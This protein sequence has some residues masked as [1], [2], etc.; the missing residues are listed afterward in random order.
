MR[1]SRHTSDH[2]SKNKS[3]RKEVHIPAA[4][5]TPLRSV[6]EANVEPQSET[7][8]VAGNQNNAHTRR[9]THAHGASCLGLG[10]LFSSLFW[11]FLWL[12]T[13]ALWWLCHDSTGGKLVPTA[14]DSE[15]E[16][17]GF[18]W[19]RLSID[20]STCMRVEM[21]RVNHTPAHHYLRLKVWRRSSPWSVPEKEKKFGQQRQRSSSNRKLFID[22]HDACSVVLTTEMA[23][24]RA[25][26]SHVTRAQLQL[27]VHC[28]QC[29]LV[30]NK[31]NNCTCF[32]TDVANFPLATRSPSQ[33]KSNHTENGCEETEQSGI[34]GQ[35][36]C[37]NLAKLEH[38]AAAT[39]AHVSFLSSLCCGWW[40]IA[41]TSTIRHRAS[42]LF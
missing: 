22:F 16:L 10:K 18:N 4:Q 23:T 32:W 40:T 28:S 6:Q 37:Q 9:M 29:W 36:D 2:C 12:G 17:W 35:G 21:H 13:G 31:D 19:R 39:T 20:S 8:N 25:S 42:P 24:G 15:D 38:A 27:A 30:D 1:I 33:R 41:D 26:I 5:K 7:P 11:K 14:Q 34:L 3:S